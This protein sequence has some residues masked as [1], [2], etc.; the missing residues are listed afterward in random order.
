MNIDKLI[1]M[2]RTFISPAKKKSKIYR[3]FMDVRQTE[4]GDTGAMGR[5]TWTMMFFFLEQ[6]LNF[7]IL[8]DVIIFS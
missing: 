8:D 7:E 1:C 2:Y 5:E 6:F 4:C 3:T